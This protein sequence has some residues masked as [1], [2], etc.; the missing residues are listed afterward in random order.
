[1]ADTVHSNK[2]ELLQ[3]SVIKMT[4]YWCQFWFCPPCP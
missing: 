1:M 3:N 2:A 4:M